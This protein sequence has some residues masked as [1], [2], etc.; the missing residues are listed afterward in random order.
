M[1]WKEAEDRQ[2]CQDRWNAGVSLRMR[3]LN[4]LSKQPTRRDAT[5]AALTQVLAAGARQFPDVLA[6]R[7]AFRDPAALAAKIVDELL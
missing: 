6:T 2:R 7:P 5:I 1:D 4:D 3:E